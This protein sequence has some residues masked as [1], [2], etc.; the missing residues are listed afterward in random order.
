M[1]K[2]LDEVLWPDAKTNDI[3]SYMK[4]LQ[5]II[6]LFFLAF[7]IQYVEAQEENIW[8][9]LSIVKFD[10]RIADADHH[11]AREPRYMPLMRSLDGTEII[12][13]GYIIPLTG[14]VAQTEFMFS[15]YPYDMCFFCGKAGPETVMEVFA[16]DDQPVDYSDKSMTLKGIF[17]FRSSD[18]NDIMFKLEDAELVN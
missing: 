5:F 4:K 1:S 3:F 6:M 9:K 12:V 2:G 15:A 18:V 14:K 7:A 8:R 11:V 16:K 13:K 17:R 10:K